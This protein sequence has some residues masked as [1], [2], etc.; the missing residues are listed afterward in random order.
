MPIHAIDVNNWYEDKRTLTDSQPGQMCFHDSIG[1]CVVTALDR[2][3]ALLYYDDR[4]STKVYALYVGKYRIQ[5]SYDIGDEYQ[6]KYAS[7]TSVTG[8]VD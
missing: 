1:G 6:D 4:P 8:L 3:K 2:G 7:A 5:F